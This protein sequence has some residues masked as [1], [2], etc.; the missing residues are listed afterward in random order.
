[1][2][3]KKKKILIFTSFFLPHLG[4]VERYND[5]LA[6]EL[7]KNG[8]DVII[9]TSNHNNLPSYEEVDFKIYRLPIGKLFKER[10]PLIKK[11][12]EFREIMDKIKD[13]KPDYALINSRFYF[14]SLIAAKFT[15]QNKIKT[16][17]ID[18]GSSH[19]SVGNKVLDFM[20]GIYEHII[21]KEV[22]KYVKNYCGVSGRVN[23]WLKHF[24]IEAKNIFY[25]SI[26]YNSYEEYKDN[27]YSSEL[28]DKIVI[29]YAGRIIKEKG[30][31]LLLQAYKNI[32]EKY[33]DTMLVIAGDGPILDELKKNYKS[34]QIMFTGKVDYDSIMSIY[35][36]SSIFVH[37]SQYP[38]GLP[39]V[40]LEAGIM[41]TAVIAT[42]RGGTVEVI[43]DEKYGIIVEENAEDIQNQLEILLN[44]P[45]R[46]KELQ[47]N[48]QE[49]VLNNFTWR[50]TAKTVIKELEKE[51]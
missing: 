14:L 8:Y 49:R 31:E 16:Y 19:M 33:K 35:N 1:M 41:K 2:K 42:D 4:G 34:K 37:P 39:T 40:I 27:I 9:V 3:N 6:H 10:Y 36:Q 30:V 11:N 28:K 26:D 24:D 13:E 48:I 50:T 18:H 23:E 43:N 17:I 46:L 32:N 15:N 5:K 22:K 38:E 12:K 25:N 20:G 47:N 21:T 44:N 45:K 51:K 7:K 29:T